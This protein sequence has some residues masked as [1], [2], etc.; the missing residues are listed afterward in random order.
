MNYNKT[1]TLS[2]LF[3]Y[4]SPGFRSN[5]DTKTSLMSTCK[6]NVSWKTQKD[7]RLEILSIFI[8]WKTQTMIF[9]KS[10]SRDFG[11]LRHSSQYI[12]GGTQTESRLRS[13]FHLVVRVMNS[14]ATCI[15]EKIKA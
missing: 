8:W 1:Q 3:R 2:V 15:I 9:K 7:G 11:L 13:G 4:A 12:L 6:I 5:V 14:I 10:D